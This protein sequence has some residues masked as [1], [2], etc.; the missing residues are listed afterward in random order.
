MTTTLESR[1]RY[2]LN[3]ALFGCLLLTGREAC[4]ATVDDVPK[5]AAPQSDSPK[6]DAP[7]TEPSKT[8]RAPPAPKEPP[9]GPKLVQQAPHGAVVLNARDVMIHG[10]TVRYE[11]PPKETIGYWSDPTD[12]VSWDFQLDKPEKFTVQMKHACGKGSGGS[13][14]AVE[15]AGQKLQELMPD[16]GS[17]HTF[18]LRTI[19]VIS[20]DK[21]GKYTLSV[22]PAN[23]TGVAVMDLRTIYLIPVV[24]K[25]K[26][27]DA[28]KDTPK[29]KAK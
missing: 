8:D 22:K 29:E 16:T 12:W 15:V 11:P 18:K 1:L 2:G 4:T 23:K 25:P 9:P 27:A 24:E 7:K 5:A 6:T 3:A 13:E 28:T 10:K 26:P 17:F 20:I 19:G 14:Y 21:P